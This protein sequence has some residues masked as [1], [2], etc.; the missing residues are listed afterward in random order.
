MQRRRPRTGQANDRRNCIERLMGKYG[1]G[2]DVILGGHNWGAVPRRRDRGR[3]QTFVERYKSLAHPMTPMNY[4]HWGF[5]P[6]AP[7]A[8]PMTMAFEADS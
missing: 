7:I 3:V 2:S 4:F 1:K 6:L 5:L 8:S